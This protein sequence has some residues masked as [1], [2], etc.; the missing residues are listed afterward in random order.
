MNVRMICAK[1][2]L[3]PMTPLG[4]TGEF[5]YSF[6]DDYYNIR[7]YEEDNPVDSCYEMIIKLHELDAL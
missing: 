2:M 4:Q 7:T 5:T 6:V 3:I 1:G